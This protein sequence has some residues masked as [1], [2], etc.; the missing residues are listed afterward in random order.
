[1]WR[2]RWWRAACRVGRGAGRGLLALVAGRAHVAFS[3][4]RGRG[5]VR[6]PSA[7][8]GVSGV[9][10]SVRCLVV[11]QPGRVGLYGDV[12]RPLTGPRPSVAALRERVG[13]FAAGMRPRTGPPSGARRRSHRDCDKAVSACSNVLTDRSRRR[14]RPDPVPDPCGRPRAPRT[15]DTAHSLGADGPR[16]APRARRELNAT[17]ARPSTSADTPRPALR[18]T[19]QAERHHAGASTRRCW[20]PASAAPQR[21]PPAPP[22]TPPRSRPQSTPPLPSRRSRTSTTRRT[23][24]PPRHQPRPPSW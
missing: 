5:A 10:C 20:P 17:S 24:P 23:P 13:L 9:G 19:R 16:I 4:R 8:R 6:G 22:H 14:P 21:Q 15:A 7:P 12:M 3:S 1:V 11:R 18:H 2:G